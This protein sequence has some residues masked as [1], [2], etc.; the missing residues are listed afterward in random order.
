MK[1][2]SFTREQWEKVLTEVFT[3]E[4]EPFLL[5]LWLDELAEQAF[6]LSLAAFEAIWDSWGGQEDYQFILIED[7]ITK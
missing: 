4:E 7:K 3:A 2:H 5:H 1:T 6:P